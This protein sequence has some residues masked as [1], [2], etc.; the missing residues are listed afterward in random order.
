M[1]LEEA[2]EFAKATRRA[3]GVKTNVLSKKHDVEEEAADVLW[4]LLDLCN[5]LDIDLEKAFRAKEA[6]NQQ[7]TWS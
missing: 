5:R 1:F 6:K 4:M 7:R 3:T 2:G